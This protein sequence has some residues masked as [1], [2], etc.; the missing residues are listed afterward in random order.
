[1]LKINEDLEGGLKAY[2][3]LLDE[4]DYFEAHEV[5]EEVWHPLRLSDHPLKNLTKGLINGAI[6]FEHI[7]RKRNEADRKAKK[8]MVSFDRYRH[9]CIEGIEDF[10]LF[11][12]A[13]QK[14][15]VLKVK[16]TKVF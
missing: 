14:I 9:L 6:A 1:M 11:E 13:C 15:E 10:K 8:V 3:Q 5:L 16:H 2:L 4:E 7:K 12:E